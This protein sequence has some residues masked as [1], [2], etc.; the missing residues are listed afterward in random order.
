MFRCC[1]VIGLRSPLKGFVNMD[2]CVYISLPGR[3]FY[4]VQLTVSVRDGTEFTKQ[5]NVHKDK[6]SSSTTLQYTAS[7]MGSYQVGDG[8]YRTAPVST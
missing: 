8:Y 1:A 7:Q 6:G 2:V 3:G 4:L 5:G